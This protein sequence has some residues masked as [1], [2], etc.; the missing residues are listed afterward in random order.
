MK[1]W[2]FCSSSGLAETR[3]A[4]K[5]GSCESLHPSPGLADDTKPSVA[6][7]LRAAVGLPLGLGGQGLG[8]WELCRS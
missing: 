5:H 2:V 1:A 6:V 7:G 4:A 3:L 8:F